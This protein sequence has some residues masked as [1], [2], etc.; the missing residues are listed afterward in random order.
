MSAIRETHCPIMEG[1]PTIYSTDPLI[2]QFKD[3]D[4]YFNWVNTLGFQPARSD[5]DYYR[6]HELRLRPLIDAWRAKRREHMILQSRS[7]LEYVNQI[8]KQFSELQPELCEELFN[9]MIIYDAACEFYVHKEYGIWA[10]SQAVMAAA[11]IRRLI[12]GSL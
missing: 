1:R 4:F 5:W 9:L 11:A 12:Q 3:L 10:D 6:Q 2:E 7:F 8:H